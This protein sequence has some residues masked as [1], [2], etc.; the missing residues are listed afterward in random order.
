MMGSSKTSRYISIL[1]TVVVVGAGWAIPLAGQWQRPERSEWPTEAVRAPDGMVVSASRMAS[2]VGAGVLAAGGNAVDAAVATGL[3]LAVTHP[4]AGNIGGGG[5]MVVR[6]PDGRA[7]TIDFRERAPAAANPDMW[8]DENGDYSFEKHHSSHLAVG[9]PGTVA[10]FAM[11]HAKYGSREWSEIVAPAVGLASDG[12]ALPAAVAASLEGAMRRFQQ[13]P[14]SVAQFSK[15]GEPYLAGERFKQPDLARSLERI[16]SHGRDGF[17]KGETARLIAEEMIHGG[18]I[19]TEED[20]ADYEAIEREPVRGTYKG[21]EI[22]GMPPPS[23]GGIAMVEMLNILEGFDLASMGHN[24]PEYV[25][26][27]AEAMRR[28]Y[29]DRARYV[30][31]PAFAEVPIDWLTSKAY[32]DEL[33]EGIDSRRA[34]PSDSADVALTQESPETTHYSVVDKDGMAVSVTYTLE[35]GYGSGIVA[36]GAG[37][38]L[39]NE[40]GDFNANPGVTTS[41]G[42][43]GTEPNLTRP[44]QRMLSSMSPSIIAKEGGLVAVIGSPGGRTIINSVMQVF[45]NLAEF[46]MDPQ[47]AVNVQRFHHQWLPNRIRMEEKGLSETD[48]AVLE[49]MGHTINVTGRQGS[50]QVIVIDPETGERVGAADPRNLDSGAVGN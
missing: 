9:V 32:A 33:R 43:I 29:L 41:Q 19:V 45:L 7:T 25:H 28:A 3:A 26:H 5:F 46:G 39:N 16:A 15:D 30:A 18:G 24:S 13:Y 47:E 6:F 42:L 49:A 21:Y 34:S 38:L 48:V 17:Y 50:T 1:A 2:N 44:G 10:G 37:F 4:T 20:L 40:M 8:L 36:A 11:A 35:F 27:L 23:S 12:F 22:I 14:A 31:D